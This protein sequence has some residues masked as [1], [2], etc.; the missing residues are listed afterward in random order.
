[1]FDL[2]R[3]ATSNEF[4]SAD[5]AAL[6]NSGAPGYGAVLSLCRRWI[7]ICPLLLKESESLLSRFP[8]LR[9]EAE[10]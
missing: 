6:F 4:D 1:M 9:A 2:A 8:R 3:H 10:R 5:H 7:R